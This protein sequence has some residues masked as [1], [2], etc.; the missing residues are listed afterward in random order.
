MSN[1]NPKDNPWKAVALVSA[2]GLD[3]VV[4]MFAGYGLG[5]LVTKYVN[6]NPIW[7]VV[8]IMVGFVMGVLSIMMIIK[9]YTGGSNE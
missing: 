5:T 7:I 2:I 3:M 9:K 1:S 4:C 8:G 6:H